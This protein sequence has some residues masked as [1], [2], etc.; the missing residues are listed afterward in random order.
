MHIYCAGT[1]MGRRY[2]VN[3]DGEL[4]IVPQ[5]GSLAL[6]TECGTLQV[7][8]GE[9]AVVPRGMKFKVD[10]V[11]GPA[12]G[13]VCENY[14]A[15]LRLPERGLV[16]SDGYANSRDFLTPVARYVDDDIASELVCKFQGQLFRADIDHCPLD[17]VAWT[18]NAVPYKY[19]LA[20][21]NAI[22]TVTYDHPDPSIFTVLTAPSASAGIA[23]IDFVIFP[24]RWLV[25]E[26]T[27]RP[28]WYHRNVMSEFMGLIHGRYD[29]RKEG[30]EP[31]GMSLHNAL[32]PHGPEA[33]VHAQASAVALEPVKLEN[34]LAF[35]F[36]TRY[37]LRVTDWAL[38]TPQ[39]Q[40]HYRD[41]WAGLE[42]H[43]DPAR[44]NGPL[45]AD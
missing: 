10:L 24:P 40:R 18:G 12:R 8:P 39:L 23:N 45:S 44:R 33:Q 4:L 13:Y 1:D 20:R 9:I 41:C 3:A 36:E 32:I 14:G 15:P 43:F 6:H 31:G 7:T 19:A 38:T 22:N 5:A 17:V 42:R 30:F 25:A 29:A 21:F 37:V 2:C 27:F 28:P 35:M 34:S 11:E 16:G 26:H